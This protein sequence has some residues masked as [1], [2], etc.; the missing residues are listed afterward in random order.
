MIPPPFFI[1]M[2]TSSKFV[3]IAGTLLLMGVS[4][5]GFFIYSM[6]TEMHP[7]YDSQKFDVTGTVDGEYAEGSCESS[8][9]SQSGYG[10]IV[11]YKVTMKNTSEE[12]KY[13]IMFDTEGNP[14]S[15]IYN[16]D[17]IKDEGHG[18]Y[19]ETSYVFK[20]SGKRSIESMRISN[21]DVDLSLTGVVK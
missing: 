6:L 13:F 2:D 7:L 3:L 1:I 17:K 21:D 15:D 4:I 8:L 10:I 14:T 18:Y 19:K 20:M 9:S 16:Y 11:L 12:L 5:G